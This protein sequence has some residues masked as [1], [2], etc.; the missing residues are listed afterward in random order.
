MGEWTHET[1]QKVANKGHVVSSVFTVGNGIPPGNSGNQ[2]GRVSVTLPPE[3][4]RGLLNLRSCLS[5]VK[6]CFEVGVSMN[7]PAFPAK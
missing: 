5:L 3:E 7:S 6:S 2:H 1:G 4:G